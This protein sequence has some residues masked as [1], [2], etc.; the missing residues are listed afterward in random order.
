MPQSSNPWLK[1]L[2]TERFPLPNLPNLYF[3]LLSLDFQFIRQ[4]SIYLSCFNSVSWFLLFINL[5]LEFLTVVITK[6]TGVRLV[7]MQSGK[8]TEASE[9]SWAHACSTFIKK[10]GKFLRD[11]TAS[12]IGDSDRMCAG[13]GYSSLPWRTTVVVVMWLKFLRDCTRLNVIHWLTFHPLKM[14]KSHVVTC[15]KQK[16]L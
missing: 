2:W 16:K 5:R 6:N 4:L 13:F 7:D 3:I 11:Y 9:R 14:S 15:Q 12:H 10:D 8:F 1:T